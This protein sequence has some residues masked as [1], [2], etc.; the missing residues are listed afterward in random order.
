LRSFVGDHPDP[1][2]D[3]MIDEL[4]TR[5]SRFR[6][7][8]A[9]YDVKGHASGLLLL[10]HPVVGPLDLHF[11]HLSLRGSENILVAYWAEPDSPS[12]D[13]LRRLADLG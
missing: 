12:A 11:Q 9:S 3:A 2:L 5:S 8:W 4:N 1:G 7:L 13:A 10:N 6:T